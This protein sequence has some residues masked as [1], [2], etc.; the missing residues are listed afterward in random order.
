MHRASRTNQNC[1][2]FHQIGTSSLKRSNTFEQGCESSLWCL[3]LAPG[4]CGGSEGVQVITLQMLNVWNLSTL[5]S[6]FDDN[7]V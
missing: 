6:H 1:L 7:N 2:V 3:C 4:S 5:Y